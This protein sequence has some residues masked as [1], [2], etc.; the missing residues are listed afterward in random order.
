[1]E[2]LQEITGVQGSIVGMVA[3]GEYLFTTS[4]DGYLVVCQYL[5]PII[6]SFTKR[7]EDKY[8]SI[9]SYDLNLR[10]HKSLSKKQRK[11]LLFTQSPPTPPTSSPASSPTVGRAANNNN[12]NNL[13][14]STSVEQFGLITT[15]PCVLSHSTPIIP[16]N[17]QDIEEKFSAKSM[18]NQTNNNTNNIPMIDESDFSQ[19]SSDA[20][21][22]EKTSSDLEVTQSY[23]DLSLINVESQIEVDNYKVDNKRSSLQTLPLP[24]EFAPSISPTID[25][26]VELRSKEITPRS[27]KRKSLQ[28]KPIVKKEK[29]SNNNINNNNNNG[30]NDASLTLEDGMKLKKKSKFRLF[31]KKSKADDFLYY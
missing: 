21:N 4:T 17:I 23:E 7:V 30:N 24:Q 26:T 5:E 27:A 14:H 1:M 8:D 29:V 28:E 20:Q 9:I 13:L 15:A 2:P 6:S 22:D 18:M 19:G 11:T 10:R 12:N 16:C 31:G 25:T 3:V